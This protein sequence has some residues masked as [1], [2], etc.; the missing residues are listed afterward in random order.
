MASRKLQEEY[1]HSV[2]SIEGKEASAD[3][4]I[5]LEELINEW[6]WNIKSAG[7]Y[8]SARTIKDYNKNGRFIQVK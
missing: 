5:S 4:N 3:K 8:L 2:K 6:V 1:Y 7:T